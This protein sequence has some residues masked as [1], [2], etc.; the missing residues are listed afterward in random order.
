MLPKMKITK[1]KITADKP[2]KIVYFIQHGPYKKSKQ[3]ECRWADK[4]T[5]NV[6]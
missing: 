2:K 3:R 6:T 4:N 5:N 1:T